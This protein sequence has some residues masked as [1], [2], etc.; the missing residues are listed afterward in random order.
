MGNRGEIFVVMGILVVWVINIPIYIYRLFMALI[1]RS[2]F[3]PIRTL[4]YV[5][6]IVDQWLAPIGISLCILF[7]IVIQI[8]YHLQHQG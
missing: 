2:H 4:F 6:K 1:G 7:A 8:Q 3:P 5:P